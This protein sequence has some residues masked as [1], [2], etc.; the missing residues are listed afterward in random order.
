[1]KKVSEWLNELGTHT[2]LECEAAKA[3]FTKETGELPPWGKGY[4]R[5]QMID[6]I[7]ARGKGG[8]LGDGDK[9]LI[10]SIDVAASCYDKWRGTEEAGDKY[11]MGSQF[12]EYVSAI[13]RAGK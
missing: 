6:Q 5:K 9:N 4:T 8:E 11:G 3:D 7:N 13:E 10:G 2:I 1:M 12:R